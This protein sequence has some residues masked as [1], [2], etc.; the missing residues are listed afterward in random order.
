[1]KK[2]MY[3]LITAAL[4]SAFVFLLV[5]PKTQNSTNKYDTSNQNEI[6]ASTEDEKSPLK[7]LRG[8]W[9]S[10]ISLDMSTT[11]RSESAFREKLEN[12]ISI[13]K[14][15]KI[16]A[17]FIHVRAFGDALY[18]SEIFPSSHILW[19]TQGGY[20]AFDPLDIVIKECQKEDIQVHA[21]INPYRIKTAYSDFEISSKSPY[22][23][24]HNACIE[25]DNG[26][27][28]NPAS[29]DARELIKKGVKEIITK[30]QVDGIH[31]DDYFY[32]TSEE[33]F[34]KE[35][36]NRYL[37]SCKS[38][39]DALSLT[40]WRQH[41]VNLLICDVYRLVKSYD[42]NIQFGISPQGNIDNDLSMGADVISWCECM[43]YVDY[44]CP[45]LYFSL[46]NPALEFKAGLDNWLNLKRHNKLRVY[47]GLG[48]YKAGTDADSGT[49]LD[50]SEILKKEVNIIR[51]YNL[52]GFILYDYNAMISENAETEMK[53]LRT[54]L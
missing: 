24:L 25:Y 52:D 44:I 14:E 42:K 21:W 23:T 11:D 4:I 26:V 37:K 40:K 9:V 29:K 47:A 6:K 28:L 13:A 39:S 35:E 50:D 18:N 30:Y 36:Y 8:M 51:E 12:I 46:K 31:F 45:Q 49:W 48:V 17:L 38:Q 16:N 33:S 7:E 43:G 20:A 22:Y 5:N 27:Y 3:F 32:P 34:D 2:L 19:G 15:N 10:Y 53:N 41:N 54:V 1:M